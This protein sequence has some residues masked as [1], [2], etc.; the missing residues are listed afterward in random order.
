MARGSRINAGIKYRLAFFKSVLPTIMLLS[1]SSTLIV[2][3]GAVLS[4][5]R[6]DF[7]RG[8]PLLFRRGLVESRFLRRVMRRCCSNAFEADNYD[9]SK[10]SRMKRVRG[11]IFR[12]RGKISFFNI[13]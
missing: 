7:A 12:G 11:E 5:I 4:L 2:E 13:L 1:R 9:N 6:H 10:G 8:L 3:E